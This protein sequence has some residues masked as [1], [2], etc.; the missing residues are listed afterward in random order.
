[1]VS[2]GHMGVNCAFFMTAL[3]TK[4]LEKI[5]FV[6]GRLSESHVSA[7]VRYTPGPQ[8]LLILIVQVMD[9]T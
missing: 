3:A 4:P 8:G 9:L 5:V 1:M 7:L 6:K 2:A